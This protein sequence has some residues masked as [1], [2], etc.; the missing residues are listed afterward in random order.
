MRYALS[1]QP[2]RAKANDCTQKELLREVMR[3]QVITYIYSRASTIVNGDLHLLN[4]LHYTVRNGVEYGKATSARL[5]N[6]Q[7]K[8]LYTSL[9][10]EIMEKVLKKLQQVLRSSRGGAKWS[11]AFCAV[12]GLGMAFEE[13]QR[14]A[15]AH[16]EAD[17]IMGNIT[18]WEATGNAERACRTIDEKFFFLTTLFRWKYHRGFNPFRN[19]HDR[20][21]QEALGSAAL[22]F[23][24]EVD[25]LITEKG[26]CSSP[27][28]SF[29]QY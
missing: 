22:E 9:W 28:F 18:E 29:S 26:T 12:L 10:I 19:M 15:H 20:K 16:Q 4:T 1:N 3:L 13:I 27:V 21:V 25:E 17:Q 24:Q 23:V 14:C 2:V 11:S 8:Y 6:R 7:L 5:A